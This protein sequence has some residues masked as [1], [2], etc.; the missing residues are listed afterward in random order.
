MEHKN[1]CKKTQTDYK[2]IG[3]SC[4]YTFLECFSYRKRVRIRRI[5]T[6]TKGI[7]DA[8]SP[9]IQR[10]SG[11]TPPNSGQLS[12]FTPSFYH[13]QEGFVFERG[14][15]GGTRRLDRLGNV[16]ENCTRYELTPTLEQVRTLL[17]EFLPTGTLSLMKNL[18]LLLKL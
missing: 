17:K 14:G 2:T 1:Q 4:P 15:G 18:R 9:E 12:P 8:K 5:R 13:V 6:H 16:T 10:G 11:I 7:R 3:F